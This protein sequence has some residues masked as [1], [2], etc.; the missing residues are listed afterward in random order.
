MPCQNG[1]Y[2]S[3]GEIIS[4][5]RDWTNNGT[6]PPEG[7]DMVT[8]CEISRDYVKVCRAWKASGKYDL[9]III[10]IIIILIQWHPDIKNP[11]MTKTWYN[12]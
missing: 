11:Y 8:Y 5:W 9:I 10:I 6:K 7:S 4:N 2:G 3:G 1:S 12:E